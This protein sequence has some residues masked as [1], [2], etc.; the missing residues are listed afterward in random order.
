LRS[1]PIF[2]LSLGWGAPSIT[3]GL[4]TAHARIFYTAG[5]KMS[6]NGRGAISQTQIFQ[7]AHRRDRCEHPIHR[8]QWHNLQDQPADRV[9]LHSVMENLPR[10]KMD[11]RAVVCYMNFGLAEAL[12][13]KVRHPGERRID[14]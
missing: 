8:A 10:V 4:V 11:C 7:T 13:P 3:Q 12:L 6:T 2:I 14:F 9:E 1:N 5:N